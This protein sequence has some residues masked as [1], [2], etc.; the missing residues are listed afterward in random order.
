MTGRPSRR[1]QPEHSREMND[2]LASCLHHA[3]TAGVQY[4]YVEDAGP[5][6]DPRYSL[7]ERGRALVF[8][9]RR[10]LGLDLKMFH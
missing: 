9:V 8:R 6:A 4:G 2:F 1:N 3:L 5:R 10:G 7:T